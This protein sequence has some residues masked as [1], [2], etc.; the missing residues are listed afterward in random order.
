MVIH[1]KN[2]WTCLLLIAVGAPVWLLYWKSSQCFDPGGSMEG[3]WKGSSNQHLE[4]KHTR[5]FSFFFFRDRCSTVELG[6]LENILRLT[7]LYR[8]QSVQGDGT[9][10][11]N[12]QGNWLAWGEGSGCSVWGKKKW[13]WSIFRQMTHL[14]CSISVHICVFLKQQSSNAGFLCGKLILSTWVKIKLSHVGI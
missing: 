7:H 3:G 5:Q 12:R 13:S 14:I 4:R 1:E 11:Q 2:T 6:C 8:A 10:L 9:Y